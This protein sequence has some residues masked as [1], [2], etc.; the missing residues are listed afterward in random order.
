MFS[1]TLLTLVAMARHARDVMVNMKRWGIVDLRLPPQRH[2]WRITPVSASGVTPAPPHHSNQTDTPS[3]RLYKQM[4]PGGETVD[5][6]PWDQIEV[7]MF[8][9]PRSMCVFY[10]VLYVCIWTKKA[11][12]MGEIVFFS[13]SYCLF[14]QLF[15]SVGGVRSPRCLC[16]VSQVCSLLTTSCGFCS[17]LRSLH[18]YSL[19][20]RLAFPRSRLASPGAPVLGFPHLQ[21]IRV[22][23]LQRHSPHKVH[24]LAN[25]CRRDISPTLWY[26]QLQPPLTRA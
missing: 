7:C 10:Y 20:P 8:C 3:V 1:I 21:H 15:L 4:F 16:D 23:M 14:L 12:G 17:P 19:S 9:V 11:L 26:V 22:F 5:H 2:S 24:K 25:I 6:S 13:P 18:N